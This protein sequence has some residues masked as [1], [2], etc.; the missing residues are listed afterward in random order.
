MRRF[1][2]IAAM[3]AASVLPARAVTYFTIDDLDSRCAIHDDNAERVCIY[4]ILGAFDG[5]EEARRSS[6]QGFCIKR[7]VHGDD[8]VDVVKGYLAAHRGQ[9][10]AEP[11]ASF[12]ARAITSAFCPVKFKS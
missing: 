3:A 11:A 8:I 5:F 10:G 1:V 2:L 4:Y 12:V 6:G 7:V 9:D